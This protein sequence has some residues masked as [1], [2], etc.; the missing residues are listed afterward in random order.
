MWTGT[1]LTKP[2][3][4]MEAD[5]SLP[6]KKIL[7][8]VGYNSISVFYKAFRN[9]TGCTPGVY[10]DKLLKIKKKEAEKERME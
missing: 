9:I 10:K 2:V 5:D 7:D 1:G 6:I 4:M 3:E 8:D